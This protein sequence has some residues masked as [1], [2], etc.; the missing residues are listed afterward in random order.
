MRKLL[1]YVFTLI[2]LVSCEEL[3]EVADISNKTVTVLAPKNEIILQSGAIVFTWDGL[4]DAES[5]RL[6]I[7]TPSFES[8]QQIVKDTTLTTTSFSTTLSFKNYQWRIRAENSGYQTNYT[9][10]SFSIEE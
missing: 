2:G 9:I 7:A 1:F 5:Y 3:I 6:Q 8:A 4:E 10:N